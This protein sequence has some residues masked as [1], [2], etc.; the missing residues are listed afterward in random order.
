M[1]PVLIGFSIHLLEEFVAAEFIVSIQLVWL[2]YNFEDLVSIL[3][4][5]GNLVLWQR[6][7]IK[8]NLSYVVYVPRFLACNIPVSCLCPADGFSLARLLPVNDVLLPVLSCRRLSFAFVARAEFQVGVHAQFQ[9]QIYPGMDFEP[10][11]K[12]GVDV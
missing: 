5:L 8:L 7:A 9:L 4:L 12:P 10:L 11:V 1:S 2:S 3:A 6:C